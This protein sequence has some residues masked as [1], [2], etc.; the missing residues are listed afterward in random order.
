MKM[1]AQDAAFHRRIRVDETDD[2]EARRRLSIV[3]GIRGD[4]GVLHGGGGVRRVR[5]VAGDVLRVAAEAEGRRGG[6]S[7]SAQQPPAQPS[8]SAVEV[9]RGRK[10]LPRLLLLALGC[11]TSSC[12]EGR[13]TPTDPQGS[14]DLP[15][16]AP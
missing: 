7:G 10:R 2:A 1:F 12:L 4:A 14:H 13:W 5:R 3:E 9:P 11:L 8:G 6:G 16:P 15:V